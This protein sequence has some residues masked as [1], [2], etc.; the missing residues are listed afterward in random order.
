M[1]ILSYSKY[2]PQFLYQ[3]HCSIAPLIVHILLLKKRKR[4]AT[5]SVLRRQLTAQLTARGYLFYPANFVCQ[6]A[7]HLFA[8]IQYG[9]T[10]SPQSP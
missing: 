8:I 3:T 10:S 4:V 7:I 6:T 1:P 9:S 2:L 5:H